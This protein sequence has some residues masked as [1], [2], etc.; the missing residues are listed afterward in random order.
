MKFLW[1]D[2][3]TTG[4]NEN[5]EPLQ[6]SGFITETL[7]GDKLE[8]FN[9]FVKPS[10]LD[11]IEKGA[12]AIHG[13]TKERA[14]E[15]GSNQDA[16]LELRDLL[17]KRN[18]ITRKKWHKVKQDKYIIVGYNVGFD[19]GFLMEWFAKYSKNSFWQYFCG[20]TYDI[21]PR[22]VKHWVE[23]DFQSDDLKLPTLVNKLGLGSGNSH[24]AEFDI[25]VTRQLL[26]KLNQ[27]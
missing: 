27:F 23:G 6:I 16:I 2:M 22:A 4:L 11:L 1:V 12:T 18:P 14:S 25:D 7:L 5:A 15:F 21:Y 19:M 9:F 20:Y 8:T 3:E 17:E 26:F 24:D 13:I 10:S